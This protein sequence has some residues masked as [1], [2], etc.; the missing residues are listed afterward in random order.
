MIKYAG[1]TKDGSIR[2]WWWRGG[3]TDD[4]L[5]NHI[6]F[7]DLKILDEFRL[8]K[9]KKSKSMDSQMINKK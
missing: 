8:S 3:P 9:K 6:L 4:V 5:H 2:P 7:Y 1:V